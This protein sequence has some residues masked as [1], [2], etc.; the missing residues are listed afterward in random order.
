ME[1]RKSNISGWQD[2]AELIVAAWLFISPWALGFFHYNA[3]TLTAMLVGATASFSTQVGLAKQQ[4]WIEWFNV[5][6]A[7]F[8]AFSS[9]I[10]GYTSL[11]AATWNAAITGLVLLTFAVLAMVSEYTKLH[12]EKQGPLHGPSH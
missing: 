2:A 8:L 5:A 1:R 3:A 7:L 10:F 11:I 12:R 4:P 6:L 9:L